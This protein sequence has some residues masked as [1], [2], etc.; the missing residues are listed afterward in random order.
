MLAGISSD[1]VGH[2]NVLISA[3]VLAGIL[4]LALWIPAA[5]NAAIVVFACTFWFASGAYVS[6][7]NALVVKISPFPEVGYRTGLLFLF[8]SFGGLTTNPIAGAI[9]QHEGGS[10]TGMKVFAGVFLL[11][12]SMAVVAARLHHTGLVLKAKF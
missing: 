6:L 7:A 10:Y 8:S 4:V 12:G 11:A 1:K 5:R 2:Y 9:L 3:C